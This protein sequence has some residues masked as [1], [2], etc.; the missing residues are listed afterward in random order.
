M[1]KETDE[2]CCICGKPLHGQGNNPE[3]YADGALGQKCCDICNIGKVLP[4]RL[5]IFRLMHK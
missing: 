3:P 2:K 1:S 5:E 4:K